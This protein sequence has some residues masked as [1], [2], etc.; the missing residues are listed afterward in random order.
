M[1]ELP[2][3]EICLAAIGPE[4][5]AVRQVDA[6]L[7][8]A[9]QN[10]AEPGT[11]PDETRTVTL[12]IKLKPKDRTSA[13]ITYQV[14]EKLAGEAPGAS[15]VSIGQDGVGKV[16]MFEQMELPDGPRALKEQP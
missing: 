11:D 9:V 15:Y 6:A 4:M 7:K 1:S 3:E 13:E 5:D 16:P 8:R 12:T 2:Y 10:I 14:K